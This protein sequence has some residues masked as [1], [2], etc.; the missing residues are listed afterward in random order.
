MDYNE[1][2]EEVIRL[3]ENK[4]Q[5]NDNN[6]RMKILNCL[7]TW[8]KK[9]YENI[10]KKKF[11]EHSEIGIVNITKEIKRVCDMNDY[12]KL[13]EVYECEELIELERFSDKIFLLVQE[14]EEKE[15]VF[16]QDDY[17]NVINKL[18]DMEKMFPK[19]IINKFK[20]IKSECLLD[21]DYLL[22]KGQVESYSFRTYDYLRKKL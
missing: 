18:N 16:N 12:D 17:N 2:Y 14:S 3:F 13:Q 7:I 21:L 10:L 15:I 20:K 6:L 11:N 9:K 8:Y 1:Y 4:I 22:N 19:I 5:S